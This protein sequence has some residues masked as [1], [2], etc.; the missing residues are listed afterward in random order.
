MAMNS[1]AM[2]A[3][4]QPG[5]V[6]IAINDKEIVEFKDYFNTLAAQESGATIKLKVMRLAVDDFKEL[7]FN[8]V[9]SQAK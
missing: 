5:D 8:I 1:P 2:M 4:I 9:L 7:N 3:G 6:V